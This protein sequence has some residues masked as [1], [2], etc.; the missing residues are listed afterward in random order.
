[1]PRSSFPG[2]ARRAS[3]VASLQASTGGRTRVCLRSWASRDVRHAPADRARSYPSRYGGT[4]SRR[5]GGSGSPGAVDDPAPPCGFELIPA[6]ATARAGEALRRGCARAGG[7]RSDGR[8]WRDLRPARPERGREDHADPHPARHDPA[9]RRLGGDT[10]IRHAGA[11]G[12]GAAPRRLPAEH[13][14]LLRAHDGGGDVRVR[15]G[16]ARGSTVDRRTTSTR[17]SSASTSTRSARFAHS[18]VGT[19][20][21]WAGRRADGEAGARHPGRA[22]HRPRPADAGAGAR[23]RTRG[24]TRRTHRVLLVA[25]PA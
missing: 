25:H 9:E 11:G 3:S 4:A 22:D 15:R 20:R 2:G 23:R 18:P 16:R 14:A 10:R 13:A 1:M 8:A 5:R 19:S 7:R 6:I 12:R 21:R 24:G 17:W